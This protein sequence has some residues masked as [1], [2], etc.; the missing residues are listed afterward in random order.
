MKSWWLLFGN[1][2]VTSNEKLRQLIRHNRYFSDSQSNYC[3]PAASDDVIASGSPWA[4]MSLVT[5]KKQ[6][7]DGRVPFR[8]A[9][10][11]CGV[12]L[13]PLSADMV[14]WME[15]MNMNC[16]ALG[17]DCILMNSEQGTMFYPS[18]QNQNL[19]IL[20]LYMCTNMNT[21]VFL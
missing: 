16:A 17:C 19:W 11:F 2:S 15:L 18:Y 9:N 4:W 1:N 20:V 14:I 5:S 10:E 3:C 12:D 7:D 21:V 13:S 6:R 8:A